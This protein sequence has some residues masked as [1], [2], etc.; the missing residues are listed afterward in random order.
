MP[1]SLVTKIV[2]PSANAVTVRPETPLTCPASCCATASA[3]GEEVA[4][5]SEQGVLPTVSVQMSFSLAGPVRATFRVLAVRMEALPTGSIDPDTLKAPA[6]VRVTVIRLRLSSRSATKSPSPCKPARNVPTTVS[7]SDTT[8]ADA[9]V[10]VPIV[11]GIS[12]SLQTSFWATGPVKVMVVAGCSLPMAPWGEITSATL[13]SALLSVRVMITVLPSAWSVKLVTGSAKPAAICTNVSRDGSSTTTWVVLPRSPLGVS[14]STRFHVSPTSTGPASVKV[15]V[16]VPASVPPVG[17]VAVTLK[18]AAVRLIVSTV[19]ASA[20]VNSAASDPVTVAVARP[21]A[22]SAASTSLS[23]SASAAS[24]LTEASAEPLVA[25]VMSSV[26]V[27]PA[28][29]VPPTVKV[30]V[31]SVT[32]APAGSS[33]SSTVNEPGPTFMMMISL[34]S[35]IAV[36]PAMALT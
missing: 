18:S 19:P 8:V 27:K 1:S 10:V 31:V 28:V 22:T 25:S 6:L 35:A 7:R 14:V 13:K 33:E 9:T 16:L 23:P 17:T 12:S 32:D 30:V 20:R 15:S 3:W 21:R 4:T 36:K 24:K 2:D 29:M 5:T 26:Q 11:A 34:P